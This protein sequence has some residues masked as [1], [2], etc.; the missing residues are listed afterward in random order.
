MSR[1]RIPTNSRTDFLSGVLGLGV[2][3]GG[4]G[5]FGGFDGYL[6]REGFVLGRELGFQNVGSLGHGLAGYLGLRFIV[7]FCCIG[8]VLPCVSLG[9]MRAY[10]RGVLCNNNRNDAGTSDGLVS[11]DGGFNGNGLDDGRQRVSLADACC[12]LGLGVYGSR[13]RPLGVGNRGH[14]GLFLASDVCCWP[15]DSLGLHNGSSGGFVD[16]LGDSDVCVDG[17]ISSGETGLDLVAA[18]RAGGGRGVNF[19]GSLL[20]CAVAIWSSLIAD[21]C[22]GGKG[23][24][25][26]DAAEA[27]KGKDNDVVEVVHIG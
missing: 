22:V 17:L 6:G 1:M 10:L 18:G 16:S 20:G 24:G 9:G 8:R 7:S 3:L 21:G 12:R 27:Q 13:L 26:R 19:L 15:G 11:R 4:F 2:R 5:L 23:S 25:G 14:H